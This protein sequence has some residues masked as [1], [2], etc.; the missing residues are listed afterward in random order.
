[1]LKLLYT[2]NSGTGSVWQGQII[3]KAQMSRPARIKKKRKGSVPLQELDPNALSTNRKKGLNKEE[4]E[5]DGYKSMVGVEAVAA[6]QH[7]Q[8]K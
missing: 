4:S 8:A 3:N 1:M 5:A 2:T 6:M 7:H